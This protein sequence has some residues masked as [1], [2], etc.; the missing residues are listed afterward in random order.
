MN[1]QSELKILVVAGNLL[2]RMGLATLLGQVDNMRVVGQIGTTDLSGAVLDVYRAD[3]LVWI[4]DDALP[5]T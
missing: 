5:E 3:V 1:T 2:A 4:V